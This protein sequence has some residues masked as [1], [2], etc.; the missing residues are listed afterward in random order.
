VVHPSPPPPPKHT[1]TQTRAPAALRGRGPP[2]PPQKPRCAPPAAA[3]SPLATSSRC[4]SRRPAPAPC[5]GGT[6]TVGWRCQAGLRTQ[7]AA[8]GSCVCDTQRGGDTAPPTVQQTPALRARPSRTC[9]VVGSANCCLWLTALASRPP[10]PKLTLTGRRSQAGAFLSGLTSAVV[11]RDGMCVGGVFVAV[12]LGQG[13]G[14]H[15]RTPPPPSAPTDAHTAPGGR[16]NTTTTPP[17]T[18]ARAHLAAATR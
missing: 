9:P 1:H 6:H 2:L 15:A 5:R 11:C 7:L 10:K 13:M 12:R 18:H 3:P 14:V 4:P 8:R 16:R 17:A